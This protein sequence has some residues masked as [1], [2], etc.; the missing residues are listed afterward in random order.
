MPFVGS[1][2][3]R[4]CSKRLQNST[5]QTA[6]QFGRTVSTC[7]SSLYSGLLRTCRSSMK[8]PVD[9]AFSAIS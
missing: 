8:T 4:N 9:G 2:I 6:K 5:T 1:V 7:I 3:R